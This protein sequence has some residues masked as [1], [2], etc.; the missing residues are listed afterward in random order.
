MYT[1]LCLG[2]C[3]SQVL[4]TVYSCP[5]YRNPERND[6]A[7]VSWLLQNATVQ[8]PHPLAGCSVD[9][10]ARQQRASAVELSFLREMWRREEQRG[11]V[12]EAIFRNELNQRDHD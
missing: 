5:N 7:D 4:D 8:G 1:I 10:V 12:G 2:V 11:W 6:C 3:V 9:L